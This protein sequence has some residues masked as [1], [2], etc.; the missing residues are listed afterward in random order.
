MT[1]TLIVPCPICKSPVPREEETFPFCSERC[2]TRDLA[3]WASDAYAIP[4][5][6]TPVDFDLDDEEHKVI[7]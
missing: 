1:K 2:Q 7:H 5:H 3:N 6:N 4:D